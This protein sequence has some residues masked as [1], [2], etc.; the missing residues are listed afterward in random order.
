MLLDTKKLLLNLC[1]FILNVIG[2]ISEVCEQLQV[3]NLRKVQLTR[4]F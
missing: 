3:D 1:S 2:E 4:S